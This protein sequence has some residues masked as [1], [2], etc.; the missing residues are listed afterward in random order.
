M[1]PLVQKLIR[2]EMKNFP[3]KDYLEDLE[4]RSTTYF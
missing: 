4:N 3:P 2:E 1:A